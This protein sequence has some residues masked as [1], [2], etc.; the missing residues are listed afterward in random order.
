METRFGSQ[1]LQ[2]VWTG[3]DRPIRLDYLD[4]PEQLAHPL[5]VV[6]FSDDFKLQLG[7][8][9]GATHKRKIF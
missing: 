3:I 2:E 8:D 5:C 1:H 4:A 9:W 7:L 6:S